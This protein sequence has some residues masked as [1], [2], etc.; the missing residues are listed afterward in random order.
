MVEPILALCQPLSMN[1]T[2]QKSPLAQIV[3][4]RSLCTHLCLL[5]PTPD[6]ARILSCTATVTAVSCCLLLVRFLVQE[7]W[8]CIMNSK[9]WGRNCCSW[10]LS[11]LVLSSGKGMMIIL[12]LP[13]CFFNY[14]YSL[15]LAPSLLFPFHLSPH[16]F[17]PSH[18]NTLVLSQVP[19][20]QHCVVL[21]SCLVMIYDILSRWSQW[22][23]DCE[24]LLWGFWFSG[25]L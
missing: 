22:W 24:G 3:H 23:R 6:L 11:S 13:L 17:F 18:T 5:H 8:M 9:G 1:L 12:P 7:S 15:S 14:I 4:R 21:A 10:T 19:W 16:S 20:E 25:L 2:I